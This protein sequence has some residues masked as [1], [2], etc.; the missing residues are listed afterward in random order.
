M[1]AIILSL[2]CASLL[3]CAAAS[4]PPIYGATCRMDGGRM[5]C[6]IFPLPADAADDGAT[7]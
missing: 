6:L 7:K 3:A 2:L 1:R 4:D 5:H